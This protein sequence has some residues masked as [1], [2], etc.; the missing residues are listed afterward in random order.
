MAPK[1]KAPVSGFKFKTG[2][3]AAICDLMYGLRD[4]VQT[5]RF[6]V[7]EEGIKIGEDA[8]MENLFLFANFRAERFTE[9][10]CSGECTICF[11]PEY[12]HKI[13]NSHQQRDVMM[14]EYS[15]KKDRVVRITKYP[16]G[17]E[18]CVETY[19]IPLLLA[20]PSQYVA[21][22]RKVDYLLAFNSGMLST[23]LTG[24][25]SLEKDF[26][27]NLITINCTPNYVQFVMEHGC[28]INHAKFTLYTSR[29]SREN[30][31][32]PA[33][34]TRRNK[35]QTP[36]PNQELLENVERVEDQQAISHKYKLQYLH[37]MLKCFSITKGGIFMYVSKDYPLVFEVKVGALGELKAALMFYEETEE[38]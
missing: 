30:D 31:H 10:E 21:P 18:S 29:E 9:F 8:C 13:L 17:E 37:H 7:T 19:E 32:P 23:I 15:S 1:S 5:V 33:K 35:N 12:M 6:H 34:K 22:K 28:M 27:Q 25:N 38:P 14:C 36:D 4:L 3:V 2:D 26:D 16:H 20:N 11:Y 24:F